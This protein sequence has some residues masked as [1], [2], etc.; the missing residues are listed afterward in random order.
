MAPDGPAT[1]KTALLA[2]AG[3]FVI[4]LRSDSDAAQQRLIGRVEHVMSGDSEG[5]VSLGELLAFIDRHSA[6]A[7][8]A[9]R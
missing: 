5:F 1:A 3:I 7:S 2:P 6:E 4:H 8:G 9:E